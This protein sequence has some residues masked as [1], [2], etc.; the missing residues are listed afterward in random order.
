MIKTVFAIWLCLT[1]LTAAPALGADE[2]I[3]WMD[4]VQG[5]ALARSLNKTAIVYFHTAWCPSCKKMEA[6]TFPHPEVVRVVNER[7]VAIRVDA[8]TQQDIARAYG[9]NGVPDLW[10]IHPDATPI[11]NVTGFIPANRLLK[12]LQYQRR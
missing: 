6:E 3:R 11:G 9:V 7:F 12:I 2:T 1:A 4:Y 10:L 5:K 8:D